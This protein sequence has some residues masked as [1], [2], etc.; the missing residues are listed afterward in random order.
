MSLCA[1]KALVEYI[2][3]DNL[4]VQWRRKHSGCIADMA[5]TLFRPK[6]PCTQ[7]LGGLGMRLVVYTLYAIGT[8]ADHVMHIMYDP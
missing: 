6:M 2:D 8:N 3:I 7:T 4:T 5:A 1:I